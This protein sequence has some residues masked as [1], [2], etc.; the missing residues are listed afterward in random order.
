MSS[1]KNWV[2]CRELGKLKLGMAACVR[3]T[4]AALPN[5]QRRGCGQAVK[6]Q[7]LVRGLFFKYCFSFRAFRKQKLLASVNMAQSRHKFAWKRQTL[8]LR[9]A[10][11]ACCQ[12]ALKGGLKYKI[13]Q[14]NAKREVLGSSLS[15]NKWP[16]KVLTLNRETWSNSQ[17][18]W[19]IVV[20]LDRRNMK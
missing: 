3:F 11:A 6:R 2:L 10:E 1:A 18:D 4:C 16:W 9:L 19:S 20:K 14:A 15:T 7:S 12:I 5:A 8:T 13:A 17:V